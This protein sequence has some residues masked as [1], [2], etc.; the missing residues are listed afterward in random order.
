MCYLIFFDQ[1]FLVECF[2]IDFLRKQTAFRENIISLSF[3]KI[4][5][6]YKRSQFFSRFE[7]LEIHFHDFMFF[8]ATIVCLKTHKIIKFCWSDFF[9]T[10]YTPGV[11]CVETRTDKV[12]SDRARL[13]ID[14]RGA[15]FSSEANSKIS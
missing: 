11:C 10:R 8:W 3:S 7:S 6:K 12:R 4:L 9:L 15:T 1:A 5:S 14:F 2:L 13:Q